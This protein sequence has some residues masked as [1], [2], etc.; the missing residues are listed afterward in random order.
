[1]KRFNPFHSD[2]ALLYYSNIA[3]YQNPQQIYCSELPLF[4]IILLQNKQ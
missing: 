4:G 1:M 2:R 3:D